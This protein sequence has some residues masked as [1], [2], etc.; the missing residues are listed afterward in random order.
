MPS[1]LGPLLAVA[2]VGATVL[3]TAA[4]WFALWI[5][6]PTKPTARAMVVLLPVYLG[7]LVVGLFF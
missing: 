4:L 5:D 7:A 3:L 6:L 2:L 1:F